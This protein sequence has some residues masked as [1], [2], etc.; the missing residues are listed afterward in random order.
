MYLI[1]NKWGVTLTLYQFHYLS[2]ASAIFFAALGRGRGG[3]QGSTKASD[4]RGRP[5]V[6]APRTAA[7]AWVA[8]GM[9]EVDRQLVQ[10]GI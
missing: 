2:S 1:S 10:M 6:S 5:I 3:W 4:P 9:E 7:I 8:A